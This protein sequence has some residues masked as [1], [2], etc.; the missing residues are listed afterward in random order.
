MQTIER[1]MEPVQTI[2]KMKPH[3]KGMAGSTLK[4]IAMI[5]ML[6][7]HTGAILL[8]RILI[9]RGVMDVV[10]QS[11]LYAFLDA[12]TGVYITYQILRTVG[13]I[14]FPIFCF[15]LVQGFLHTHNLTKYLG[16][17]F[18]FALLS[19]VPF[20]LGFMGKPFA[21]NYQNVYFTLF[22]G[23]LALVGLRMA[24]EKKEWH[25]AGRV[26]FG[27]LSVGFSAG[28]AT[29]LK[30]DYD[31]LGV[32][33]IAVLYLLRK[34][35]LLSMGLGCAVLCVVPME[36]PALVSLLPVSRYNGK[37]GSNVKWLFYLFYPVHILLLYLLACVLGLGSIIMG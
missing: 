17:L 28:A 27:V 20:D 33:V 8:D 14:A 26:L 34:K 25:M 11:S 13:R 24:E 22:L 37:R 21:W 1:D 35:R 23:V 10:D 9:Q 4:I 2:D 31:M 12:N 15:L 5:S 6:M 7:D 16:G 19:E 18:L 32:L 29:L 36:I 3:R 30:T